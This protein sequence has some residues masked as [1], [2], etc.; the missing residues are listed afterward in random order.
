[1]PKLTAR[2][3]GH[4]TK[5]KG[6]V[7]AFGVTITTEMPLKDD[8]VDYC[9]DCIAKM[10]IQCAWCGLPI[11]IGNHITLYFS[12]K[13]DFVVPDHAVVYNQKTLELVGCLRMDCAS[14][15]ADRAGFWLPDEQGHGHV[16][17]TA[18]MYALAAQSG[19]PVGVTNLSDPNETPTV[20][21]VGQ[22]QP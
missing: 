22:E 2:I 3:C 15:G 21:A 16:E 14:T 7:S 12:S 11:F 5:Q 13:P 6:K 20:G 8:T 9:L 4:K 1:M 19:R 10:A 17:R 18:S